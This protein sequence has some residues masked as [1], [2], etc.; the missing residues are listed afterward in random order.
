MRGKEQKMT[1]K[2]KS[3][4][5]S[6]WKLGKNVWEISQITGASEKDVMDVVQERV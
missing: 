2:L 6:L 5:L 4:I 1:N 3:K